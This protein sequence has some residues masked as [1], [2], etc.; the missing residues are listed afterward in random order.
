MTLRS[1][2]EVQGLLT[3]AARGAG[4][5][6]AQAAQFGKAGTFHLA[7]QGQVRDLQAALAELPQGAIV[8]IPVIIQ[9]HIECVESVAPSIDLTTF[10][11]V[12]AYLAAHPFAL[13][14]LSPTTARLDPKDISRPD[15]P[16]RLDVEDATWEAWGILAQRIFV[17]ETEQSRAA[18]AGAGLTDND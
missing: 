6:A 2:N 17:P 18:G 11:L 3:K 10:S 7:A 16:A 14:T 13:C 12:A 8:D 4:A 9:H 1:V 5:Q 15:L